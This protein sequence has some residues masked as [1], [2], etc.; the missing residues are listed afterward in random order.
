MLQIKDH[1]TSILKDRSVMHKKCVQIIKRRPCHIYGP[2]SL[3]LSMDSCQPTCI[4]M[5]FYILIKP[6]FHFQNQ[7]NIIYFPTEKCYSSKTSTIYFNFQQFKI[8]IMA[9]FFF[10]IFFES[11]EARY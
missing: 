3:S 9:A 7:G 1:F 5:Y 6:S 10:L 4:S 8:F 2:S 11:G